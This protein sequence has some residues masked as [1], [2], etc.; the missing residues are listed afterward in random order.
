MLEMKVMI[1]RL[2]RD[3]NFVDPD[4]KLQQ[5]PMKTV[6]T[7]KPKDGVKIGFIGRDKTR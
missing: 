2:F 1:S 5:I 4:P 3:F 6:V 7:A